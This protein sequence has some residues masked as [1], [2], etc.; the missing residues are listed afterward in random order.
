LLLNSFIFYLL[1]K[2]HSIEPG[3]SKLKS[4]KSLSLEYNAIHV[5]SSIMKWTDAN[6]QPLPK[7]LFEDTVL[8][9][10]NL[11]GNNLTNTQ[12]VSTVRL[13]LYC[14]CYLFLQIILILYDV[15]TSL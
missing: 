4:L 14:D 6:P 2:L 9:D 10:L 15:I 12:L 13:D 5:S 7:G 11:K 3:I 1:D 8:I